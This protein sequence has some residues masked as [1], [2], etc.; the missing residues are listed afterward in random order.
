MTCIELFQKPCY[1]TVYFAL[2]VLWVLSNF[3][4]PGNHIILPLGNWFWGNWAQVG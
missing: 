4:A 1:S 2:T 3:P